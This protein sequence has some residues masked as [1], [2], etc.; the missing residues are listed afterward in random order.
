MPSVLIP[1]GNVLC[2]GCA[3]MCA[4][5]TDD[6]PG[7]PGENVSRQISAKSVSREG[8][9]GFQAWRFTYPNEGQ[10]QHGR[11]RMPRSL[12][13]CSRVH[14]RHLAVRL[15]G[16]SSSTR[17]EFFQS[18][19]RPKRHGRVLSRSSQ[20]LCSMI[21]SVNHFCHFFSGCQAHVTH[22]C[23][24]K[25]RPKYERPPRDHA[26]QIMG[27]YPEVCS[28]LIC[29]PFRVCRVTLR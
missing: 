10:R 2:P 4:M 26:C 16:E 19:R 5:L 12:H 18:S 17:Y 28:K 8:R 11:T 6:V 23:R 29:F 14:C 25:R 9:I 13:H 22:V 20:F 7:K 27:S 3:C 15:L 1:S 21:F 24:S